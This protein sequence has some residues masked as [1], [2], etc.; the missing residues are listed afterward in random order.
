[1]EKQ[2]QQNLNKP[3]N[4]VLTSAKVRMTPTA[5]ASLKKIRKSKDF[6]FP[7]GV[8]EIK[9][10]CSSLVFKYSEKSELIKKLFQRIFNC[11]NILSKH[12]L[13]Y[14]NADI[15]TAFE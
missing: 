10:K 3:R 9:Y 2:L 12:C 6:R 4:S 14:I 7:N 1:M 8:K 13:F 11:E 15:C 5:P